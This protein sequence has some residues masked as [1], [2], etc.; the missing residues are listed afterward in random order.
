ML[1]NGS[2]FRIEY[3]LSFLLF[4]FLLASKTRKHR[5]EKR[6]IEK[7]KRERKRKIT[8]FPIIGGNPPDSACLL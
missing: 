1:R 8:L 3:F 6:G 4:F 7:K 5:D 2:V